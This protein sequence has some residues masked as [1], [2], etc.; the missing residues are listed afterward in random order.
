MR[1]GKYESFNPA[2]YRADTS[3]ETLLQLTRVISQRRYS[4]SNRYKIKEVKI[5]TTGDFLMIVMVAICG[6]MPWIVMFGG[7]R[8]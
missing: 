4:S 1:S 8:K 3:S 5:M 6:L 2:Y 7:K